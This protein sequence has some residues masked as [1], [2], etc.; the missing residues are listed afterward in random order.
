MA[1]LFDDYAEEALKQAF[2]GRF[3]KT[4]GQPQKKL[5][6]KLGQK[7]DSVESTWVDRKNTQFFG[8]N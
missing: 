8:V 5:K 2:F 1:M 3:Q 7:L 6:A 4:Q